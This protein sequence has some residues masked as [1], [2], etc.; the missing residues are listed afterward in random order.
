MNFQ[1]PGQL[2]PLRNNTRFICFDPPV[3]K[4]SDRCHVQKAK[5][6]STSQVLTTPQACRLLGITR[7]MLYASIQKK[8]IKPWM[9]VGCALQAP[10]IFQRR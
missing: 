10:S 5:T 9:M 2:L 6:L 1:L 7:Q 3:R 8:R 4:W